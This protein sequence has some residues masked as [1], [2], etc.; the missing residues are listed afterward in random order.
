MSECV[1]PTEINEGVASLLEMFE[2]FLAPWFGNEAQL[3]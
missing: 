2:G 1:T 3:F